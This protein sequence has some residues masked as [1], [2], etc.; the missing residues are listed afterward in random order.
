MS[1]SV[2]GTKL[3]WLDAGLRLAVDGCGRL[4]AALP[5]VVEQAASESSM[6]ATTTAMPTLI[7]FRIDVVARRMGRE[8]TCE[9]GLGAPDKA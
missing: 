3:A 1:T 5:P 8:C 7:A 4:A 2:P 9:T 6:P